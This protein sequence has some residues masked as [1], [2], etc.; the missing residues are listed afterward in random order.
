MPKFTED[1]KLINQ[2]QEVRSDCNQ[3]TVINTGTATAVLNGLEIAPGDQ[4]VSP[5]NENELN[6]TRYR[7]SFTGI[8]TEQVLIIRKIYQ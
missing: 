1:F 5:G 2:P 6:I 3:L 8:G 4:Y 7:L